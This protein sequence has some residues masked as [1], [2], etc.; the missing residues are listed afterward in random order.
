MALSKFTV[1]NSF[2]VLPHGIYLAFEALKKGNLSQA[3]TLQQQP[4]TSQ[5]FLPLRCWFASPPLFHSEVFVC[6]RA[7]A[8][9]FI[10]RPLTK[11]WM[12]R[13]PK[14]R[15]QRGES[16]RTAATFHEGS[17]PSCLQSQDGNFFGLD[18]VASRL[19]KLMNMRLG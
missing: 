1:R 13:Q 17:F 9:L 7:C 14:L 12:L 6:M 18:N 8:R 11:P 19:L 10:I 4:V 3:L 5:T 16:P 2:H 15:C